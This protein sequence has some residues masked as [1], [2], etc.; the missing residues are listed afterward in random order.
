LKATVL[1]P[2]HSNGRTLEVSTASALAQ[3]HAD[4][5]VIIVGDGISDEG[6]EAAFAMVSR[7]ARVRFR[8]NPKGER[9]GEL[10]RHQALEEAQGEAIFYLSDD[11][12]WLPWHLEVLIPILSRADFVGGTVTRVRRDGSLDSLA[13]D[14]SIPRARRLFLRGANR[15]PLSGAA[16]RLDSYVR[17][18]TH[19]HP[20]PLDMATDLYFFNGFLADS[21]MRAASCGRAS[22]LSF[23]SRERR[24]M[25]SR[26]RSD[27]L[28]AWL[29]R[30]S[31]PTGVAEIEAD[32]Q[33]S[34]QR[35]AMKEG[36]RA[37]QLMLQRG[38]RPR[39][40]SDA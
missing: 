3:T 13:H 36:M 8:D 17:R 30:M 24:G 7:D 39:A 29:S 28:R 25:T 22:V 2:S 38:R 34:W 27:E 40:D 35:I 6:R 31:D 12:L 5:E 10:H 9:H 1:I 33:A 16:H 26:E 32:V 21:A 37:Q 14:L 11:D 18:S 19:W 20:T 23:P 15:L 4:L